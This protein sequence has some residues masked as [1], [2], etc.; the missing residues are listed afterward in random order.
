[1]STIYE[2]TTEELIALPLDAL[3]GNVGGNPICAVVERLPDEQLLELAR[4]LSQGAL[5]AATTNQL[6]LRILV[7]RLASIMGTAA[8]FAQSGDHQEKKAA[9]DGVMRELFLRFQRL[10][11]DAYQE[12]RASGCDSCRFE[13]SCVRSHRILSCEGRVPFVAVQP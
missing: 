1:M 10:L 12:S 13:R 2:L 3:D 5:E 9:D 4:A 11:A 8:Y 6:T 7:E